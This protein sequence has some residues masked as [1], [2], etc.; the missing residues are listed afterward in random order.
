ML[1]YAKFAID[2]GVHVSDFYQQ[3]DLLFEVEAKG[4]NI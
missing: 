1:E 4:K 3:R 2:T